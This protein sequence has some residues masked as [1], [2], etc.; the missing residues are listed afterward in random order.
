[1]KTFNQLV[2]NTDEEKIDYPFNL[3]LARR[4]SNR[5][6]LGIS[7]ENLVIANRVFKKH[8]V[9]MWLMFGTLLGAVRD[10]FLIPHDSDTDVGIFRKDTLAAAE[11]M[12]ELVREYGF[13]FIR[14]VTLDNTI[15][16]MRFDEYIDF[17]PFTE[18]AIWYLLLT[19][20]GIVVFKDYQLNDLDTIFFLGENFYVPRHYESDL[21]IWYGL[22]W[23]TPIKGRQ[24]MT[25][26]GEKV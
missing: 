4:D 1:M 20:P 16:L 9:D 8:G 22:D 25:D 18:Q 13:K 2:N 15:S 19:D 17:H 26:K 23:R 12:K 10:G 5:I 24:A 3:R 6:N 7:S 21:E 14:N 11:A